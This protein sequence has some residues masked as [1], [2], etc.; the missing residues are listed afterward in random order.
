MS[1]RAATAGSIGEEILG[2]FHP[3]TTMIGGVLV[4]FVSLRWLTPSL[5]PNRGSC[6]P[7]FWGGTALLRLLINYRTR[8][9]SYWVGAIGD[10]SRI[11]SYFRICLDFGN[12]HISEIQRADT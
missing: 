5:L 8:N 4:G 11:Q 10:V 12:R 2:L 6:N 1:A 3:P 9:R 7:L